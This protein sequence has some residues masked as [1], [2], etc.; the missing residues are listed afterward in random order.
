MCF[1]LKKHKKIIYLTEWF[2]LGKVIIYNK[3]MMKLCLERVKLKKKIFIVLIF[4]C[5]YWKLNFEPTLRQ[6]LVPTLSI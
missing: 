2:K 4:E 3:R 5:S 6:C 1:H